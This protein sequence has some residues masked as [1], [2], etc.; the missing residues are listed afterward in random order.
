MFLKAPVEF[1]PIAASGFLTTTVYVVQRQ[2]FIGVLSATNAL[3]AIV[4]DSILTLL[5]VEKLLGRVRFF[6][7]GL[8]P[9]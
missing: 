7:I 4:L 5:L 2:K 6:T 1:S 3:P 8:V 9:F